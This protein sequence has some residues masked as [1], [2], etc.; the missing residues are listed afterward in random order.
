[1][2]M[3]AVERGERRATAAAVVEHPLVFRD[4]SN[5]RRLASTGLQAATGLQM[6]PAPP[7]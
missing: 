3:Q 2:V 1:V 7:A 4:M 5:S 6:E